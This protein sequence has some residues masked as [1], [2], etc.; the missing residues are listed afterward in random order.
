MILR[1]G[2]DA[3][4]ERWLPPIAAGEA[5]ASFALTEPGGG[6]DAARRHRRRPASGATGG[7]LDGAKAFITNAGT[8][9]TA[10]HVVTAASEAGGGAVGA[11]EHSSSR[12]TPT[13][14]RSRRRTGR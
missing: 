5:L 8:P 2:S 13:A 7:A 4:Q 12:P 3:Q 11:L 6:T 9:L 1:F 10:V 14:S